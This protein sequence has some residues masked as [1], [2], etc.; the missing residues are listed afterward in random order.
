MKSYFTVEILTKNNNWRKIFGKKYQL[1]TFEY[2]FFEINESEEFAKENNIF[3]IKNS[4]NPEDCRIIKFVS[5]GEFQYLE[6][7]ELL[8]NCAEV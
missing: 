4:E 1:W 5:D 3:R 2:A 8:T 6:E 7:H